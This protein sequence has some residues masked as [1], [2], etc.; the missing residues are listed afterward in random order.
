MNSFLNNKMYLW[1]APADG[2][3]LD[4]IYFKG[5][6]SRKD[7]PEQLEFSSEVQNKIE[8]FR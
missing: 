6:N 1:L 8:N 5:Y 4:R 7:I 2:L 3:F